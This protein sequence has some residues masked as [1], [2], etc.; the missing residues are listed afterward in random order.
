M[1]NDA[2]KYKIMF[3][4][5][6]TQLRPFVIYHSVADLCNMTAFPHILL[7][8]SSPRRRQLLE[9][10]EIP[11]TVVKSE[12][13][14]SFPVGISPDEAAIHVAKVKADAVYNNSHLFGQYP[15]SLVLAA[16]TMVVLGDEI[17][18][19]PLDR[20]H[21]IDMITRLSGRQHRVITA[22]CLRSSDL[23]VA[24]CEETLVQFRTLSPTEIT[25]YVGTY[26]P[27]DKA[28]SYAIQEW[29]GI[30]GITSIHGDYYNVMGLPV[31]RLVTELN[32]LFPG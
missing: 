11:F 25:H 5:I 31:S 7:A 23:S 29:I 18:G 30:I 14:E 15:G 1:N 22:V 4:G 9:W 6:E 17:L 16:D 10:A 28:G 20:E 19:K 2:T 13:D 24:F 27:F 21:A 3:N 8:S 12:T 26:R 32:R